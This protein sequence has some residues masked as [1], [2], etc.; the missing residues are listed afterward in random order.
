MEVFLPYNA[1]FMLIS[2]IVL[3]FIHKRFFHRAT[4]VKANT[5]LSQYFVKTD[6]V[7]W[8]IDGCTAHSAQSAQLKQ[9]GVT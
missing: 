5:F 1:I 9:K 8:W 6:S 4:A 2:L 7:R 3:Y